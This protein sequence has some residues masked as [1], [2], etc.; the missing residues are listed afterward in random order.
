MSKQTSILDFFKKKKLISKPPKPVDK[1]DF[2]KPIDKEAVGKKIEEA[3]D[4]VRNPPHKGKF[5]QQYFNV[6][7]KNER[8]DKLRKMLLEEKERIQKLREEK[9]KRED[10]LAS[11]RMIN[12]DENNTG[13]EICKNVFI[14]T[15]ASAA[16]TKW[17]DYN[18]I[19]SIIN[20][21]KDIFC[22][23]SNGL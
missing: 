6:V 18:N 12:L 23:L 10:F 14:G 16:N 20:C 9:Q 22:Y 2:D 8:D 5:I 7:S 19:Y 3:L 4:E 1:A 11:M 15:G 17:L 21:T 13:K